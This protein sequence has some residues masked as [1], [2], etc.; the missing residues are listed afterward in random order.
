MQQLKNKR[1]FCHFGLF[2]L[3]VCCIKIK[4]N[5]K[6]IRGV[7]MIKLSHEKITNIALKTL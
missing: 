5:S 4:K 6:I 1:L 2:M 7:H 3:S